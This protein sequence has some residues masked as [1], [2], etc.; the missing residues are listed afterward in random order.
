M[1]AANDLRICVVGDSFVQGVGDL[2]GAGWVG[3]LAAESRRRGRTLTAYNIGVRHETSADVAERWYGEAVPRMRHADGYG[4]VYAFGVND[5]VV[6]HGRRRVEHEDSVAN[7]DAILD[8]ATGARW[9]CLVVGP[10]PIP[11]DA[12]D[13]DAALELEDAYAKVCAAR[14]IP[15]VPIQRAL[16]AEPAWW[17]SIEAYGDGAH[18]DE[19]GYAMIAALVAEGGWWDWLDSLTP[20]A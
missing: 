4:M 10:P 16:R 6:E 15:F 9:T 12:N 18:C 3:R 2:S 8:T 7:L 17:R 13:V 5:L 14:G 19:V 20:R 11:A 1:E